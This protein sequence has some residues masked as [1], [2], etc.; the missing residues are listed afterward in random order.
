MPEDIPESASGRVETTVLGF[1]RIGRD[2]ELKWALEAYWRDEIDGGRLANLARTA[3]AHALLPAAA[4][5]LDTLPAGDQALYDHVL[6]TALMLGASLGPAVCA[7]GS[8]TRCKRTVLSL[9]WFY[10]RARRSDST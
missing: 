2:R 8:T 5:G 10:V 6:D 7:R 9:L 1:P 3:R 4:A